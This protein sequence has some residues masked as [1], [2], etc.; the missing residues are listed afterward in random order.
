MV[1]ILGIVVI[2]GT[3]FCTAVVVV[4]GGDD[5]GAPHLTWDVMMFI[6]LLIFPFG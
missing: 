2:T 5:G 4:L 6:L 3:I 1:A